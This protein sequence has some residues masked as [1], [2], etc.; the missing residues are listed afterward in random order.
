LV[1]LPDARED[2]SVYGSFG[3]QPFR[4][5]PQFVEPTVPAAGAE[6]ASDGRFRRDQG[7]GDDGPLPR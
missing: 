5:K 3:D 6:Y 7:V 2:V 1:Q 4:A